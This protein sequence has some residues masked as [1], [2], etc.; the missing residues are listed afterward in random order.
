MIGVI[1][2][3]DCAKPALWCEFCA[4]D[5]TNCCGSAVL[6]QGATIYTPLPNILERCTVIGRGFNMSQLPRT[7]LGT[8]CCKQ[9]IDSCRVC[10]KLMCI[11]HKIVKSHLNHVPTSSQVYSANM[12]A[13]NPVEG[14][15]PRPTPQMCLAFHINS[16]LYSLT[17]TKKIQ[18]KVVIWHF[19]NDL[20]LSSVYWTHYAR[21]LWYYIATFLF[22]F[23]TLLL[24]AIKT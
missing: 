9:H 21:N 4:H 23:C 17:Y 8:K 18:K 5:G 22:V 14:Y 13:R 10:L 16:G 2:L 19:F 3:S 24:S 6:E 7:S 20:W 1:V 12:T 15:L 11:K